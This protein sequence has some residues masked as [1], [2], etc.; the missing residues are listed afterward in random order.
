MSTTI[1]ASG[2]TTAEIDSFDDEP[3]SGVSWGAIL[4]GAAAAAALS[5]ILLVLGVGL[6]F[7]SVS[8]WSATRDTAAA[9]GGAAVPGSPSRRSPRRRSA[10]TWPAACACAGSTSHATR[11][12]SATPRTACW[13]GRWPASPP[14]RSSARPS[15]ACSRPPPRPAP[16]CQ[17]RGAGTAR[18]RSDA[19]QGRLGQRHRRRR[20]LVERLL[21]RHAYRSEAPAPA[22]ANDAALRAEAMRIFVNDMRAGSMGPADVRYLGQVVARR[23]GLQPADA[24]ARV[25]DTF[26]QASTTMVNAQI[27][28]RPRPTTRAEPRRPAR[29]GC[30][31]RC[32]P[33]PSSPASP[34]WSAAGSATIG[35]KLLDIDTAQLPLTSSFPRRIPTCVPFFF[36]CSASRCRSSS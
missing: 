36:S 28:R 13:P 1:T 16:R 32:W 22:D 4:A 33:A 2:L 7:S 15:A 5:L 17:G 20:R 18:R 3:S 6:G 31:W 10:A 34:H 12:G 23:T 11:S 29:S 24:E 30:S 8:P 14:P 21:R 26:K 19:R 9:L 35:S 25:A 27:A